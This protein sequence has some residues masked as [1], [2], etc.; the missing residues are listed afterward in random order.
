MPYSHG[1]SDASRSKNIGHFE[2]MH[3]KRHPHGMSEKQAIAAAYEIQREAEKKAHKPIT[4][5]KRHN[6]PHKT[7]H[8]APK[9]KTAHYGSSRH[10][11]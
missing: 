3:T 10:H 5:G 4:A 6:G 8:A 1:Y 9:P 2:S 7:H 11:K